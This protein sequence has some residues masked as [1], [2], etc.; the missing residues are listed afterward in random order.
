M[1]SK[2]HKHP[3]STNHLKRVQE[4]GRFNITTS[5]GLI[6]YE[7]VF[8]KPSLM[9]NEPI[10][11]LVHCEKMLFI[12]IGEVINIHINSE[13]L[14]QIP[15]DLLMEDM[16][17][18]T[19]QLM[20]LVPASEDDDPSMKNDWRTNSHL[21]PMSLKV[22]GH[23]IQP[24]NPTVST[25]QAKPFYLFESSVILVLSDSLLSRLRPGDVKIIP[26]MTRTQH[27]PYHHSGKT[28]A[29]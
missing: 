3:G 17:S 11:M 24:V 25:Q 14:E 9:L 21:Q 19:F 15:L 12:G 4:L 28:P 7:S 2:Y 16:V 22:G 8:G 5:L 6:D 13:T 18:M 29:I 23:F 1:W 10:A 20:E 27:F 26:A